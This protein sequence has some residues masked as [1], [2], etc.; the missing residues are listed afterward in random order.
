MFRYYGGKLARTVSQR[1][2]HEYI[3]AGRRAAIV[4]I[5]LSR[6]SCLLAA[7][8]PLVIFISRCFTIPCQLTRAVK[9]EHNGLHALG[10]DGISGPLR[11]LS[12]VYCMHMVFA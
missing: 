10:S 5:L 11:W 7:F 9:Y 4:E 2:R 12:V 3:L 6:V 8:L 1:K